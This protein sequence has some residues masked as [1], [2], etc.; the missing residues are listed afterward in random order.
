VQ[1]AAGGKKALWVLVHTWFVVKPISIPL[2]SK[3]KHNDD[4]MGRV[5]VTQPCLLLRQ[6]RGKQ[7]PVRDL[8]SN[9]LA[10]MFPGLSVHW[11]T[12]FAG[13][14]IVEHH[15]TAASRFKKHDMVY[16]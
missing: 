7:G 10:H 14:G 11:K 5:G 4:G 15:K 2:W 6:K 9:C 1:E 13:E 3:V 16:A 12:A 8:S